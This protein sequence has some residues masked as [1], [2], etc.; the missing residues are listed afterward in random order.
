MTTGLLNC[1]FI[2]DL[3]WV[4]D[5]C[6]SVAFGL[7]WLVLAYWV[8]LHMLLCFGVCWAACCLF[9]L[10]LVFCRCRHAVVCLAWVDFFLVVKLAII[11]IS[12]KA[13]GSDSSAKSD[14]RSLWSLDGQRIM[15]W[16]IWVGLNRDVMGLDLC[17]L[18][19]Y[20]IILWSYNRCT[21][22]KNNV[23]LA[24]R[25]VRPY[26]YPCIFINF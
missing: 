2:F 22:K 5:F 17:F 1:L 18:I 25:F 10:S 6:F 21:I 26:V 12:R 23:Y 14:S 13:V 16:F 8:P 3:P 7:R 11:S 24:Y 4:S 15:G 19:R 20:L 9:I